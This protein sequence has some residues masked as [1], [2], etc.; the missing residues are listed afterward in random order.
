MRIFRQQDPSYLPAIVAS[1]KKDPASL[2]G[3]WCMYFKSHVQGFTLP[4]SVQNTLKANNT[5]ADCD[6][7]VCEDGDVICMGS[8]QDAA[9][10][11]RLAALFKELIAPEGQ[12]KPEYTVYDVITD[13]RALLAVLSPRIANNSIQLQALQEVDFGDVGALAEVFAEAKKRRKRRMPMH[14]MIVEDDALTRRIVTGTFKE[15]YAVI[16]A[17]NAH[18]AVA[19]YLMHAPDIVFLDIGLP[20]ASGF[21]VLHRILKCDPEA[22]VVMFSG[23]HYLDNITRALATGAS[24]F[25]GKPFRRDRMQAYIDISAVHHHK[26]A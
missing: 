5:K 2:E 23:N 6:I 20:D 7:V 17:V 16:A 14:V 8:M 11:H 18:E 4:E 25:V 19:N 21:N 3:W 12:M 10:L 9:L 15:H 26:Y 22:Y 13:W 24:G 1:L